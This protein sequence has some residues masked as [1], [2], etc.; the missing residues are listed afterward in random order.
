M[1]TIY[2]F[3]LLFIGCFLSLEINAQTLDTLTKLPAIVNESSGIELSADGQVWNLTDS[4]GEAALYLCDTTGQLLRT[5]KI[6][7][8]WN[9]DWEDMT[10]DSAG[11]FFI[12]NMGNNANDN[13]DLSIFKIANPD[14]CEADSIEAEVITFAFEDQEAFPPKKSKMNFDCEAIIWSAGHL[15]LFTKHRSLPM[16]TNLYRIP[17]R[18]GHHIARKIGS[19]QMEAPQEGEHPI[20][21]YW[22]TAADISPDGKKVVLLSGNK[23]WMFY[24]YEE[25]RFLDGQHKVIRLG[26]TTQKEAICFINNEE[27]FITDEFLVQ[28]KVGQNLYRL[29]LQ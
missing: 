18:K 23:L 13:K 16:A 27:L 1:K 24:D 10:A 4:G 8:A 17:D 6:T 21:D 20:F 29:K 28:F 26:A 5:L 19:F 25:D 3:I 11:N 2:P 12:G 15:Y 22:I 7:N 14:A 9:R